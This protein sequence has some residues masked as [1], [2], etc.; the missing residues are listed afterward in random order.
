MLFSGIVIRIVVAFMSDAP[1]TIAIPLVEQMTLLAMI[2]ASIQTIPAIATAEEMF[3][4]LLGAIMLTSLLTGAFLLAL[5]WLKIGKL[6]RYIPY[7]VICGFLAGT[8]WLLVHGSMQVMT[9]MPMSISQLPWLFQPDILLRWL[10]GLIFAVLL[11]IISRRYTHYLIIPASFFAALGVFYVMLLLTNTSLAEASAQ[12]W[13][14]GPFAE[15]GSWQLLNFSALPQMNWPVIFG[16]IGGMATVMVISTISLLLHISGHELIIHRDIDLNGELRAVGIADLISGLG[17]GMVGSHVLSD[18]LLAYKME[19]RNRSVGIVGAGLYA[20][21]LILNPS[22][23]TIFPKAVLGGL[24]MFLGLTLLV[25]WVYKAWFKLS[26]AD[27]FLVVLILVV[28]GAVGF[29]EGVGVGLVVAIILFAIDYSRSVV[30]KRIFSGVEHRSNVAR[31]PHQEQV[32]DKKG[33]QICILELQGFIFFGTANNIFKQIPERI[34]DQKPLRFIVLDFRKVSGLDSAAV[35]S[36]VRMKQLA[37]EH[38]LQLIFTDLQPLVE[39]KLRQGGCLEAQ[40]PICLTFPDLDRGLEWCENQILSQELTVEETLPKLAEQLANLFLTV[41]QVP[42]FMSYLNP[43][44]I[45]Q[46]NYLFQQGDP[47]D[48]LYFLESGQVSV[49]LEMAEGQKKRLRTFKGGTILGEMGLYAQVPRSASVIADQPSDLYYLSIEAFK[50]MET[51]APILATAFHRFIVGLVVERL[52]HAED[53]L[54][55]L[56]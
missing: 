9:D 5:G 46:G 11:L 42:E 25:E 16:Q 26:R 45:P 43:M 48:G 38:Q 54:Q 6:I 40:D 3:L 31:P 51:E 7:P 1:G 14:L 33:D 4:T 41:D 18:S 30:T 15:G 19:A 12:G 50:K 23:L 49:W 52:N 24:L 10:S 36:F 37:A 32:L 28:I 53:R 35:H 44:K 20:T 17:G 55:S 47:Y 2:A 27:F 56:L 13:L 34:S 21:V 22:F 39:K 29:V 8:G